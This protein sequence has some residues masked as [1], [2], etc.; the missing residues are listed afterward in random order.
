MSERACRYLSSLVFSIREDPAVLTGLAAQAVAFTVVI[1]A[2]ATAVPV[3]PVNQRTGIRYITLQLPAMASL[4]RLWPDIRT[5]LSSVICQHV[6]PVFKVRSVSV[7]LRIKQQRTAAQVAG[8]AVIRVLLC[9]SG[10]GETTITVKGY[11]KF[12]EHP[13]VP[14]RQTTRRRK[15]SLYGQRGSV[16]GGSLCISGR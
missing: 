9:S 2:A 1:A 16:N 7:I 8:V 13:D 14:Y 4:L 3:I 11:E 15:P 6:G 10:S 12:S 5:M